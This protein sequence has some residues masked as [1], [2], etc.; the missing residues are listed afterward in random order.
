[1]GRAY[2]RRLVARLWETSRPHHR[3]I[4]G[5]LLVL[6]TIATMELAQ[7]YLVK[8]AIDE[9]MLPGNWQGLRL[10]AAAFAIVLA[11]LFALRALEGYLLSVIGQRVMYDLRDIVFRHLLT[12]EARFFDRNPV[13]RLMTRVLYDVEAVSEAFAA[14]LFALVADVVTLL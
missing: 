2:D 12:L 4:V 1:L 3:L 11:L 8:V 7:P 6:P 10:V 13:G 5:T 14:G 9:Y